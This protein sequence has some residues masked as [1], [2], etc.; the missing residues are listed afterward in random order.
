VPDAPNAWTFD[1]VRGGAIRLTSENMTTRAEWS[2]DGSGIASNS[3]VSG[4]EQIYVV[5]A[6]GSGQPRVLTDYRAGQTHLDDWSPDGQWLLFQ[7]H[8]RTPLTELFTM[9][10]AK[11]AVAASLGMGDAA[12]FSPDGR[13]VAYRSQESGRNEIYVTPLRALAEDS[14]C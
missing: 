2:P 9:E 13:W 8:D 12:S 5:N 4:L 10:T 3:A 7:R 1:L 6:D 11:T 14:R